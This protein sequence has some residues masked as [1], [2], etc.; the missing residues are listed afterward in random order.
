MKI[1][2]L[3]DVQTEDIGAGTV[4]WQFA[5]I[6]K[7][8]KI[9]TECNI[10]CH[11]FIEKNVLIG[12]NVT[13]KAGVYLWEG[14]IIEDNVFVG[15]NAT[16]TN[17]KYPRSKKYPSRFQNIVLKEYCSIGANATILGDVVVGEHAIVGAGSVVTKSVPDF[18]VVQGNPA[19]IVAWLDKNGEKIS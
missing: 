3:A 4:I 17:D 1:H 6:L 8:A 13:I 5:V 7:G 11:T 19:R 12:N 18:A 15:P 16:F 14:V 10:N 9:G 2:A